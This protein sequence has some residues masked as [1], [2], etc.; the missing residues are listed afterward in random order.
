MPFRQRS[1]YSSAAP[2]REPAEHWSY[3]RPSRLFTRKS[4][5]RPAC[6]I[7]ATPGSQSFDDPGV[8]VELPLVNQI[9]QRVKASR[10]RRHE[11][12]ERHQQ[13]KQLA[14]KPSRAHLAVDLVAAK[15]TS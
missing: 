14:A 7:M 8:F 6:C 1:L 13:R 2:F 15:R 9:R 5:R 10:E 4:G 3:D 12:H 11:G